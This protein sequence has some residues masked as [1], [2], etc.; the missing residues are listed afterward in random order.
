MTSE[1]TSPD[2]GRTVDP[3]DRTAS[4]DAADPYEARP[5]AEGYPGLA[6]LADT[7]FA[8]M[9][10]EAEDAGPR[11][12]RLLL[13]LRRLTPLPE[14][15]HIAV[16]GCGPAP[17]PVRILLDRGFRVTG[18]EPVGSFVE[19][20]NAYLGGQPV[21]KVGAAESIPL[22]DGSQDVVFLESVLEHVDSPELSLAEVLR[23]LRP[24]GFAYITTTN[25]HT[26]GY[27]DN[28]EFAVALYGKLPRLVKESFVFVH[29][30]YRP[31][32]ARYTQR[33]AV[34]W[35]SYADLCRL[36]RRV[37][38]YQ[39]YSTID[40]RRPDDVLATTSKV[41]RFVLRHGLKSIQRSPWLRAAALT[42][43][44]GEI[45]MLKRSVEA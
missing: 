14:G 18:I 30:H 4:P 3:H 36:G 31:S 34:H 40:L 22:A 25:R 2:L 24:G 7:T 37:G 20:A 15:A 12:D 1:T 26:I 6:E 42:Q 32:L 43:L 27:P 8:A 21:V 11:M 19:R 29:L 39:F 17:Q 16:V 28:G 10:G 45:I 41:N 38:F 9:H 35:F 23:V 33:P 13:R 5:L 44:G